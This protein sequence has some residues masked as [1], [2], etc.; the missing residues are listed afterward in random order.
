MSFFPCNDNKKDDVK[1][2]PCPGRYWSQYSIYLKFLY[3]DIHKRIFFP[4]NI[5]YIYAEFFSFSLSVTS[6]CSFLY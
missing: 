4:L 1:K 3:I 2:F 5:L 6:F